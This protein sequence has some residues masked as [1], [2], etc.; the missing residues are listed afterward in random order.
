M[1]D[2]PALAIPAAVAVYRPYPG[3]DFRL[4]TFI[5]H[6]RNRPVNRVSMCCT[7]S[8][9]LGLF[10]GLA[11]TDGTSNSI[12][13]DLAA[14]ANQPA[15]GET[16]P[17]EPVQ[18]GHGDTGLQL[19]P[20]EQINVS[21][22][23]RANPSV[24]NISTRS[25]LVDRFFMQ[26]REAEGSG[27][28]VVFDDLGHILTNF[29]VV[30]GARDIEVTLASSNSSNPYPAKVVGKDKEQDIA[31]LRIAA[32]SEDLQPVTLGSSDNLRVGQRVYILGNPFSWDGT[33]TT[34]IISSLNRD[35]PSRVPGE[36]M[37][38][39][40]QTDAAMNPGNSGGP[41]LDTRSRMIG[42]C[43]A[44]ATKTGQN[45]GVGFAIPIDR[46]KLIAAELIQNGLAVRANIGIAQ[47]METE[48]GLVVVSLTPGGP[49]VEAGLRGFRR[50][51]QRRQQGPFVYEIPTIDRTHAD[52]ILAVDGEA[53]RTGVRFRDKIWEYKPGDTITLTIVRDRKIMEIDIVLSVD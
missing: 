21:V 3:I 52:R 42:M 22:Y 27:S 6:W 34:G 2:T 28:G 43:V 30:E 53:M 12:R 15:V 8:A 32:P 44:I 46:I 11:L 17:D 1:V 38:S 25:V 18:A 47:V 29:H 36:V 19:T 40:I 50:V 39:L 49:A 33:L 14:H 13:G 24:V 7:L 5:F 9:V 4:S 23:E 31:I 37:S 35:L 20:E 48:A 51:V 45:A 26:R 10:V 16:A 41:L